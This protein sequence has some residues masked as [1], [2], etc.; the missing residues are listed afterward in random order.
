MPESYECLSRKTPYV[1]VRSPR[2]QPP[3]PGH[4]SPD[5]GDPIAT[6]IIPTTPE[7]DALVN[8]YNDAAV[9][10]SNSKYSLLSESCVDHVRGALNAGGIEI[11]TP[12]VGSGRSKR[13]STRGQNTN[14][15]N[16]L[17]DSLTPI[18]TVIRY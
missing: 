12:I 2:S 5:K 14:L 7:Q 17:F 1:V 16:T 8:A 9:N 6:I 10:N 18:G 4:V 3:V 15:P 13:R 11:P